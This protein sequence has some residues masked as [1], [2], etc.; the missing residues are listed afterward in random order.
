MNFRAPIFLMSLMLAAGAAA[1]DRD[2]YNLRAATEDLAV[3]HS[4]AREG[5]LAR[6]DAQADLNFG[7]RFDQADSNRDGVVTASEMDRYIQ[8]TYGIAAAS[9]AGSEKKLGAAT[10]DL[11]VF[12]KLARDGALRREAAQASLGF[13]PRFDHADSNRDGV[14]TAEEMNRYVEQAYGV[15]VSSSAGA[16]AR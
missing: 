3:F 10:E 11:A 5:S 1:S 7:P 13:G 15:T 16:G 4:L 14:V 8:Q 12:H 9:S 6:A 2:A